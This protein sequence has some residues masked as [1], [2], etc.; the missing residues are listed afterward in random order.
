MEPDVVYVWVR[1]GGRGGDGERLLAQ[2][3]KK[4]RLYS[5][6]HQAALG[7]NLSRG[8]PRRIVEQEEALTEAPQ[9]QA[10]LHTE[11]ER[12][13][14]RGTLSQRNAAPPCQGEELRS[15][16]CMPVCGERP[17]IIVKGAEKGSVTNE[18]LCVYT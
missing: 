5:E 12:S 8:S 15:C 10:E 14:A 13:L 18:T 7:A 6:G 9:T 17:G 2:S 4:K 1:V 11:A 3:E 16:N